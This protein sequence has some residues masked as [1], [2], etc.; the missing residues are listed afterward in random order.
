MTE[1]CGWAV[2]DYH[3]E[4][5]EWNAEARED[6]RPDAFVVVELVAELVVEGKDES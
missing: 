5:R 1:R 6:G 2:L 3:D 4:A